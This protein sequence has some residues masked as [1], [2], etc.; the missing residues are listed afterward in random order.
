MPRVT[1]SVLA[2][3]VGLSIFSHTSSAQE[4]PFGFSWG[5]VDRIP[6]PSLVRREENITL[7]M[8]QNER[9][10]AN[11]TDT[12]EIVLEVCQKEGLQQVAWVSRLFSDTDARDRY[13]AILAEGMRRYGE[14]ERIENGILFWKFGRTMMVEKAMGAGEWRIIMVSY[15]PELDACSDHHKA[16]TGHTL[17]D[18]WKRFLPD[19]NKK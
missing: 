12:E 14:A 10:P 3:G 18:H 19:T 16:L 11:L 7:L 15:G 17:S 5:P 8:Y 1:L 9:L 2:I 6:R 4:A 13:A